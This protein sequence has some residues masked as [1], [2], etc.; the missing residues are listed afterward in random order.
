MLDNSTFL[1]HF[2][3]DAIGLQKSCRRFV[4]NANRLFSSEIRNVSNDFESF[5]M[6]FYSFATGCH[7]P[8]LHSGSGG[9]VGAV[10]FGRQRPPL[11]GIA[12]GPWMEIVS[13]DPPQTNQAEKGKGNMKKDDRMEA[14]EERIPATKSK[15]VAGFVPPAARTFSGE[16]IRAEIGPAQMCSPSPCP[17]SP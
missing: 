6:I 14:R 9:S 7:R 1:S 13:T 16:Q 3:I 5:G 15:E 10:G 12:P 11:R 4:E 17:L 2:G 8:P